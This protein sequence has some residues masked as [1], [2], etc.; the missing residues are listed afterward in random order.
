MVSQWP[1]LLHWI[2]PILAQ[3]PPAAAPAAGGGQPPP[4]IASLLAP[5]AVVAAIFYL[6]VFRPEAK[7]RKQRQ[8]MI[9]AVKKGDRVVTT[10]GMI[11]QVWRADGTEVVLR[12]DKDKDIK[13]RFARNSIMEVLTDTSDSSGSPS[14]DSVREIEQKAKS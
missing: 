10:G 5:M 2:A 3:D 14:D 1:Q 6:L 9:D 11:G 7:K 8:A 13:V 4:G 12:I